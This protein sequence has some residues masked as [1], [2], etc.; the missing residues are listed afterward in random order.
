MPRPST[1]RKR[2]AERYLPTL[3]RPRLRLNGIPVQRVRAT[4]RPATNGRGRCRPGGFVDRR[5]PPCCLADNVRRRPAV[6]GA[7]PSRA[8]TA[9]A[10]AAFGVVSAEAE[11]HPGSLGHPRRASH[12]REHRVRPHLQLASVPEVRRGSSKAPTGTLERPEAVVCMPRGRRARAARDAGGPVR[13]PAA[14][15]DVMRVIPGPPRSEPASLV[16]EPG[17]RIAAP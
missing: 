1:S 10:L 12:D 13:R 14:G 2:S 16:P 5:L 17:R 8:T 7:G 15:R 6:M 3:P 11:G 4:A 9:P